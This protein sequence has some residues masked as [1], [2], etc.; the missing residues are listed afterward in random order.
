MPTFS[1]P[2]PEHSVLP[3]PQA[4]GTSPLS[5]PPP[6]ATPLAVAARVLWR[7]QSGAYAALALT[8][9]MS[10]ARL[11][12]AERSLCTELCYGT[13]RNL[14]RLDRAL[15]SQMP[16]GQKKLDGL[17]QTFLRL[18]AYQLLFMQAQPHFVVD[19]VVGQVKRLRGLRLSGFANAVL[20]ALHRAGEPPLPPY[21]GS[22]AQPTEKT[23]AA[24]SLHHSLHPAFV[25][26]YLSALPEVSEA[27]AALSAL[28]QPA[29]TW[30]RLNPLRAPLAEGLSRLGAELSA[31]PEV[32]AHLPDAVKLAGGHP[33]YG[34]AYGEGLFTAQDLAAQYVTHFLHAPTEAGPLDLPPGNLLDACAGVGG[35]ACHVATLWPDRRVDALDRLP[36]KLELLSDHARRLGCN[37]VRTVCCDW[38]KVS[39]P[40]DLDDLYAAVLLDAPCSGSGVLRRH[41]EARNRPLNLDELVPLQA[42][43][44]DRAAQAVMPGGVLLYAVCSVFD[45]EGKDQ[46]AAFLRRQS[47]F[48]PLSVALTDPLFCTGPWPLCDTASRFAFRS[49]PHRHATDGF[50]AARLVA[51]W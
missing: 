30:V 15:L 19:A 28:G 8:A 22:L 21:P 51:R 40:G 27:P 44:L 23:V 6:G 10:K 32:H 7:V 14:S 12:N 11:G 45:S 26:P 18:G 46:I 49:W 38:L 33:F 25:R 13:L 35:K 42:K 9:E 17:T 43:L 39:A 34:K 4:S 20:R 16:R 37:N 3:T 50:Y 36:R 24:L 5:G 2:R 41:P 48:S 47:R 29:P 31:Q 1:Q